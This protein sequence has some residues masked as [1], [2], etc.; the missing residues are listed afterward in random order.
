MF[1]YVFI[2]LVSLLL[3]GNEAAATGSADLKVNFEQSVNQRLEALEEELT[4]Y[5]EKVDTLEAKLESCPCYKQDHTPH[6]TR[7]LGDMDGLLGDTHRNIVEGDSD[8]Q[9][10]HNSRTKRQFDQLIR[11]SVEGLLK[12]A[13]QCQENET[14]GVECSLKPGPKGD[15]G[16]EGMRGLKGD[17]GDTGEKGDT[18]SAG[19]TGEK[20]EKGQLGYPGYKGCQGELGAVGPA[21]PQG[22]KGDVGA[23]G[24][25][26]EKGSFG[27]PKGD[28]GP[29]GAAGPQGVKGNTGGKGQKGDINS[30]S[31]YIRWGRDDCPYGAVALFSGR[32]AGTKYILKGG[33]SDY[34]C[35]PDRPRYGSSYI[36]AASPLFGVEY[37][38]WPT[39]SPRQ[40]YDNMPCV[41]CYIAT[42]SAMFVQEASYLC[43]SG[44]SREYYG[45]M[46]S[47]IAYSDR[48]HKSTICVDVNAEVVPGSGTSTGPS[49]TYL[50]SVECTN[51]ELPCPPYVDG[52]ILSCAV[53]TK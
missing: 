9:E 35:L 10:T 1:W 12:N 6:G 16:D 29:I 48:Q 30:G 37:E 11:Q 32:A 39:S 38:R 21:G 17:K 43:P 45:Y 33:T 24:A 34:L 20:G 7:E 28:T 44:W 47:E 41:V 36:E 18:G 40:Y 50:M 31:T 22:V 3:R 23:T 2:L 13:L 26:G 27:G 46:M 15:K 49:L 4:H 19:S 8:G 53:C 5:K 14:I 51:S 42:R 25:K 52:R